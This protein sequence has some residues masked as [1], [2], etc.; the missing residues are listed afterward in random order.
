[1]YTGQG[2]FSVQQLSLQHLY[3]DVRHNNSALKELTIA[4]EL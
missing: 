1:M 4:L 3:V 2:F